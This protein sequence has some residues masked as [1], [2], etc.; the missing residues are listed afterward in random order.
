MLG[1]PENLALE[2]GLLEG[3]LHGGQD[4]ADVLLALLALLHH[5]FHQVLVG[6]RIQ[7]LEGQI[8]QL[9]F[10]LGETEAVGQGRVNLHGLGGDGFLRSSCM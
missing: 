8:L 9:P 2:L 1:P 5:L 7:V 4:A 3:F 10:D 6:V